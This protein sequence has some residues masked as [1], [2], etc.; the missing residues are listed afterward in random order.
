MDARY[1]LKHDKYLETKIAQFHDTIEK[2]LQ[3]LYELVCNMHDG[4][5]MLDNIPPIPFT[6]Q[7]MNKM[8]VELPGKYFDEFDEQEMLC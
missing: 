6:K 1:C 3:I 7:E 5:G 8:L 2:T 4:Q